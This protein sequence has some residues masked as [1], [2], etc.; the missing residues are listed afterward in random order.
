MTSAMSS[1]SRW[2]N[3]NNPP[4]LETV[5]SVTNADGRGGLF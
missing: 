5:V 2:S 1:S 3:T 4:L